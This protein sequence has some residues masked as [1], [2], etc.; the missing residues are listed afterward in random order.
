MPRER[1]Y[2]WGRVGGSDS[3][4]HRLFSHP[5][6]VVHLVQ[7]FLPEALT[8][9]LDFDRMAP[10]PAKY[11]GRGGPRRDGDVIWRIP[12]AG[13]AGSLYLHLMVGFQSKVYW[14][15]PV[16]TDVCTGLHRQ[17]II[18]YERLTRED[19][20]PAVVP[21]VLYNG[22]AGWTAPT[23]TEDLIALPAGSPLW[24]WQPRGGYYLVD[25]GTLTAA[26]ALPSDNLA[27][28][29][30]RLE[31]PKNAEELQDV[32]EAIATWFQGNSALE[33]LRALFAELAKG[34]I[35]AFDLTLAGPE[36]LMEMRPMLAERVE[37]WKED[38]R[39]EGRKEGRKEGR[40]E[41]REELLLTLLQAR[42][43]TLPEPVVRRVE[44][45]TAE[46]LKAWAVRLVNGDRLD[47]L[48]AVQ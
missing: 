10:L 1:K 5:L 19:R 48:L 32:L 12:L 40:E 9:G 15:M 44:D 20:L 8:L 29:L 16:R 46:Q 11:Y 42:F 35:E 34:A 2:R 27:S 22:A 3:V 17:G 14:W 7:G 33:E 26:G 4:Y 36:Y 41:G 28:L 6:M 47:D 30:F 38:L 24:R 21:V 23:A 18:A 43:G 31:H 39:E 25:M 13:G 37:Q 45:A